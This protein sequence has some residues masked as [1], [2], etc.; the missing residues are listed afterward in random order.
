MRKPTAFVTVAVILA[1]G[2]IALLANRRSPAQDTGRLPPRWQYKTIR[3]DLTT[4]TKEGRT[5]LN[6]L[7][8]VGWELCESVQID[9]GLPFLILKRSARDMRNR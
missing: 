6:A 3:H 7:G 1:I 4:E 2:L 5:D 9:G 8:E